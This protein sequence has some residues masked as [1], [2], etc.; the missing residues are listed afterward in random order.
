MDLYRKRGTI[1]LISKRYQGCNKPNYSI[2]H[3]S[4]N[5]FWKYFTSNF[6]F[7]KHL[8]EF[9]SWKIIKKDSMARKFKFQ[10][11]PRRIQVVHLLQYL[12]WVNLN[13]SSLV[14]QLSTMP[15]W[16]I[17]YVERLHYSVCYILQNPL[18]VNSCLLKSRNFWTL[19]III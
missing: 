11:H 6:F 14:W 19:T 10:K 17:E 3:G 13:F 12:K 5:L 15:N 8:P 1:Y 7:K 4:Y 18:S 16:W 2:Y 9:L